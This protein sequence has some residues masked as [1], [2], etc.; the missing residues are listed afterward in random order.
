MGALRLKSHDEF[1]LFQWA[2]LFWCRALSPSP[3]PERRGL[4]FKSLEINSNRQE[5]LKMLCGKLLKTLRMLD[6][7]SKRTNFRLW[8]RS[9]PDPVS[10]RFKNSPPYSHEAQ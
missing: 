3:H 9:R 10:P 8:L 4:P 1:S 7:A 2:V 5:L 6:R